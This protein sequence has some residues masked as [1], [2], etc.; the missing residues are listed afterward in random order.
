MDSTDNTNEIPLLLMNLKK[1]F[2]QRIQGPIRN[3]E[4]EY[5]VNTKS[6][7]IKDIT[8][9][10]SARGIQKLAGISAWE[11]DG[12]LKIAYHF[13]AKIGNEFLD[14]KITIVTF[15]SKDKKLIKSITQIFPNARIFE[16]EISK[17]YKVD[18]ED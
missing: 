13:I 14:T 7:F 12:E 3:R 16:E 10:F 8:K 4:R 17:L 2:D 9:Y 18:F 15:L 6:E 11:D 1:V 5:Q